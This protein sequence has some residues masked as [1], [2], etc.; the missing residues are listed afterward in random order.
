MDWIARRLFGMDN[1]ADK[2]QP[3]NMMLRGTPEDPGARYFYIGYKG[4]F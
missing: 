2:K 4:K 3:V 1:L